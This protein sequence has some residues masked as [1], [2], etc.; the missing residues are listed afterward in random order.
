MNLIENQKYLILIVNFINNLIIW[1]AE[2]I[3]EVNFRYLVHNLNGL[4]SPIIQRI[5]KFVDLYHNE[6]RYLRHL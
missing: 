3:L 5:T 4:S 1:T 6:A 2:T